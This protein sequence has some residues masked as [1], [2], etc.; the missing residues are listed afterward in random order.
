ML[1]YI[2]TTVVMDFA[3]LYMYEINSI[4]NCYRQWVQVPSIASLMERVVTR[5][6]KL[7]NSLCEKFEQNLT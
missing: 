3:M 4:A 5:Y 1:D 7:F 2:R 6:D